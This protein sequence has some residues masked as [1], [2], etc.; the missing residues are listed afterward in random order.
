[1][2][3]IF[4]R[5]FFL[6]ALCIL[7]VPSAAAAK[8]Q[9][10]VAYHQD[11]SKKAQKKT[12]RGLKAATQGKRVKP[13][14]TLKLINAQVL[15][16]GHR[17]VKL[18]RKD[19]RTKYV[20]RDR[21]LR[22]FQ[23][24]DDPTLY[25]WDPPQWNLYNKH[26]IRAPEAWENTV[27]SYGVT[28]G[29]LDSGI[30]YEHPDLKEQ[31]WTNTGEIPGNEKD[32]DNNGYVDDVYGIDAQTGRISGNPSDTLGHGTHVA[33]IIGAQGNNRIGT[34]GVNWKVRIMS[35]KF[36]NNQGMGDTSDAI[37]GIEYGLANGVR[38]FNASW[39]TEEYE[40]ALYDAIKKAGEQD[41]LFVAAAG[42]LGENSDKYPEYPA[43]FPLANVISVA[44]SK[45]SGRLTRFS[46]YGRK[47]VD[48]AAPG[49]N[50]FST[51]PGDWEYRYLD[52]TSMATP[53]VVG[54]AALLLSQNPTLSAAQLKSRIL[55]SVRTYPHFKK[56]LRYPGILDARKALGAGRDS[57]PRGGE[58][59]IN[60]G[61]DL[62]R[63]R[64]LRV[65]IIFPQ[66]KV[67]KFEISNDL[68]N[69]WREL[70]PRSDERKHVERRRIKSFVSY[71][72]Q[73][74]IVRFTNR[75][76][77]VGYPV[78]ARTYIDNIPPGKFRIRQPKKRIR[79]HG[80]R[81][82]VFRWSNSEE[83]QRY[84]FVLRSKGQRVN[85]VKRTEKRHVVI[86]TRKLKPGK[87]SYYVKAYDMAG[88]Y[89]KAPSKKYT[90]TDL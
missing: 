53:H 36:L 20:Q 57:S 35:V 70:Q 60:R 39:G 41:A 32:D 21:R 64:K 47:S 24:A 37:K 72:M 17:E 8:Q 62:T 87:Y 14:T 55:D 82:L 31:L 50:I 89:A 48:L 6:I 59:V 2:A 68:G 23:F 46:N 22:T 42:N 5:A 27:G 63:W 45:R 54:V 58:I 90:L 40:Q 71:G 11:V 79:S 15:K 84:V 80:R 86:P 49:E 19:P 33:G 56:K 25:F 10:I 13:L 18:L 74:I 12:L 76:G 3:H 30:A 7:L 28:V 1:M 43:A 16:L 38:I 67:R 26:G 52:G 66:W 4:H 73:P 83:A 51:F 81:A 65:K 29:V 34:T 77:K 69:T 78:K 85:I 61:G 88:N 44:A 9:Y 75:R